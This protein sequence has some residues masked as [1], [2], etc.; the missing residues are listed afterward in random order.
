[1]RNS[2]MMECILKEK[3]KSL[4]ANE[5]YLKSKPADDFLII[6][7]VKYTILSPQTPDINNN[8]IKYVASK[9]DILDPI[10]KKIISQDIIHSQWGYWQWSSLIPKISG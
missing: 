2:E 5:N 10:T 7:A 4:E 3:V 9:W 1:M 8:I 6:A